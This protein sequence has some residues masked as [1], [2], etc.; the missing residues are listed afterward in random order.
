MANEPN[1]AMR[2]IREIERWIED[3]G[4][5]W[6]AELLTLGKECVLALKMVPGQE[7]LLKHPA[8]AACVLPAITKFNVAHLA[9]VA[10]KGACGSEKTSQEDTP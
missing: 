4:H 3:D 5:T 9:H 10:S 8:F 7:R 1:Q 2:N 6:P